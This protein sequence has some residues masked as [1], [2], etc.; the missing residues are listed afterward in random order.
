M[1]PAFTDRDRT[2]IKKY[3]LLPCDYLLLTVLLRAE[4]LAVLLL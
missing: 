2:P 1:R 3:Q 4:T